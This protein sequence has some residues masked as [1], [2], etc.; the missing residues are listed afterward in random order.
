MCQRASGAPVV[1]WGTWAAQRLRLLQGNPKAFHSSPGNER[2]FCPTCG[3][4]LFIFSEDE[5]GLVDVNL[6]CLDDPGQVAPQYHIWRMSRISWLETTD[7]L[8][9]HD[10]GWPDRPARSSP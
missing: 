4:Q 2:R 6:A 3:A 7:S 1:A 8:P 10:D 9:R 5:P